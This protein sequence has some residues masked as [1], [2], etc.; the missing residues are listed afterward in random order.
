MKSH[1]KILSVLLIASTLIS[2]IS[3]PSFALENNDIKASTIQPSFSITIP[4]SLTLSGSDNDFSVGNYNVTVSGEINDDEVLTVKPDDNFYLKSNGKNDVLAQIN[5][6]STKWYNTQLNTTSKG[7][8]KALLT[9]GSWDGTFNFDISLEKDENAFKYTTLSFNPNKLT[10]TKNLSESIEVYF[11][12]KDVTNFV[13]FENDSDIISFSGNTFTGLKEGTTSVKVSYDLNN[14]EGFKKDKTIYSTFDI[15]VIPCQHNFTLI[16]ST[17]ATCVLDSTE[18]YKCDICGEVKTEHETLATGH[19]A[20]EPIETENIEPTCTKEGKITTTTYCDICGEVINSETTIIPMLEHDFVEDSVLEAPSCTEDGVRLLKCAVCGEE[21][22]EVISRIGHT[23]GEFEIVSEPTCTNKGLKVEKCEVCGAITREE[24][25][26]ALGHNL[27]EETI[28]STCEKEGKKITTCPRCDYK[29]E[30]S[31]PLKEHVVSDFAVVKEPSC[32]QSGLAERRCEVCG[33]LIETKILSALGHTAGEIVI[34]NKT[35]ATCTE[36]GSYDEVVYCAVCNEELSRVTK[37][38]NK[39]GHTQSNPIEENRI[40]ATC[41]ENGSCETVT[42]CSLCGAEL[43][44]EK[45]ILPSTGH[46]Y[47]LTQTIETSCVKDGQKIFTCSKCGDVQ[48]EILPATGHVYV[49]TDLVVDVPPTCSSEGV[50]SVHCKVCGESIEGTAQKLDKLPHTFTTYVSNND[51]TCTK[52]GTKTAVCDVCGD[53]YDVQVD[54][55]TKLNHP[56]TETIVE[57]TCIA[58]GY[59]KYTCDVCGDSVDNVLPALGHNFVNAVC[60]RCGKKDLSTLEPGLYDDSHNLVKSW[61]ALLSEGVVHVDNNGNFTTNIKHN[62]DGSVSSGNDSSD[63]LTGTLILPNT[64]KT[65]KSNAVAYLDKLKAI[66][67]PETVTTIESGSFKNNAI[68]ES[69]NIDENNNY[70]TV[71]DD[72]LFNKSKTA[73][74]YCPPSHEGEVYQIPETVTSLYSG[75]FSYANID[76]ILVQAQLKVLAHNAS[77]IVKLKQWI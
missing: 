48:K 21:K 58:Q 70:F 55:G 13:S 75:A 25:I 54:K 10:I 18:E 9:A 69:V 76:Y 49:L 2:N 3:I 14:E 23:P 71:E 26:D 47:E 29:E 60:T 43:M 53:A 12:G 56:Y 27:I 46:N 17:D 51:A 59:T 64:V 19:I 30:E 52:D 62:E 33:S 72:I 40:E 32:T 20:K 42:Y 67:V 28:E 66:Y 74:I 7:S 39:F 8:I 16:N 65:I 22:T 77:K 31:L 73:L 45:N 44:R 41:T 24:E 35:D 34:E 37:T 61:S 36:N 50:Q 11:N 68:L 4:K 6:E 1:K 15:E 63:A 5:Q 38:I 57:P